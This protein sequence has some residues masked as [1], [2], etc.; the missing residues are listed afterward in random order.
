V[1]EPRVLEERVI[2]AQPI[3]GTLGGLQEWQPA[4]VAHIWLVPLVAS[5]YNRGVPFLLTPPSFGD[6]HGTHST[7]RRRTPWHHWTLAV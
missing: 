6:P 3:A 1:N 7:S 4:G 2:P 5:P